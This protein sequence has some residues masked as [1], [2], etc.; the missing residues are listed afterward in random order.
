MLHTAINSIIWQERY[1]VLSSDLPRFSEVAES[2]LA[3]KEPSIRHSTLE[4]YKGHLD[5]HLKPYFKRLKINRVNFEAIEKFTTHSLKNGVTPPT[6]R[7]ILTTLGAVLTYAVR[8]RYI[9]YNPSRDVEKPKGKSVHN[10]KEKTVTLDSGQ[11]HALL[12]K[13][14]ESQQDR[15]LFMTAVL[16]GLREGEL[17]G[18]Q[19]GDIDWLN[20][21]IHVRRTY[22]HRRFYEP[23]SKASRRKVDLAPELVSAFKEWKLACPTGELDLVFPTEVG[24][25]EDANNML[26]RRF[27]PALRRAGLPKVRFHDLRH[28]YASLLVAQG[29]HPKYIQSQLGHSSIQVTMDV[30]GHLM[31]DVNQEAAI[32]LGKSV[33]GTDSSNMVASKQKEVS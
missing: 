25:P 32:K 4:Q 26:K 19:W 28:T 29:E 23:K 16:T 20:R 22:N 2:W 13:G 15:M 8:N 21:Q 18:L 17:F 9:D 7:K 1:L 24:T 30:Y 10:E 6:L 14:A 27:Y 5:N 31:T 11:I 33:F 3:S 12:D